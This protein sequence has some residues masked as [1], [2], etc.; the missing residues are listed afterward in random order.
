MESIKVDR[1]KI[2]GENGLEILTAGDENGLVI[3]IL[4]NGWVK[5]EED[6]V[7]TYYPQHTVDWGDLYVG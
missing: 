6:D 4:P 7:I 5:V 1:L 3:S 2:V